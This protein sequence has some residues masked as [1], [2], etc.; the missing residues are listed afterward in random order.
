MR[1]QQVRYF[2][3]KSVSSSGS[4]LLFLYISASLYSCCSLQSETIWWLCGKMC[5]FRDGIEVR[6]VICNSASELWIYFL[7]FH[8]IRYVNSMRS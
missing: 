3:L 5:L 1:V 7:P 6:G 2:V 4:G 8:E